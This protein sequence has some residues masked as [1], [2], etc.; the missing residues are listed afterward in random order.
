MDIYQLSEQSVFRHIAAHHI[1]PT[2]S[3]KL[4]RKRV[5]QY[6][7]RFVADLKRDLNMGA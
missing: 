4:K 1:K 3:R 2:T 6:W 5:R 7:K